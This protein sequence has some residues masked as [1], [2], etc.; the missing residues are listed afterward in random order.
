MNSWKARLKAKTFFVKANPDD[1]GDLFEVINEM[2][3]ND[4]VD[5][6]D[7]VNDYIIDTDGDALALLQ[8]WRGALMFREWQLA[9]GV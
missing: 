6:I 8:S 9:K 1:E 3:Q 5:A 4:I 7:T 2:S